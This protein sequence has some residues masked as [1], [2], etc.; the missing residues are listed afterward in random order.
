M[1]GRFY[2]IRG[3]LRSAMYAYVSQGLHCQ[4]ASV[5]KSFTVLV[6]YAFIRSIVSIVL[7]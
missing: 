7:V 3:S 4:M 6:L 5:G 1:H 2:V